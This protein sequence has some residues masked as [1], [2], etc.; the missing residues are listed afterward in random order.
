[1]SAA[2]APRSGR[3]T[4]AGGLITFGRLRAVSFVHSIIY[5]ALL[6]AWLAPGL[7]GPTTVLGWCH[8]LLWIGMSLA[9]LEATRKR[10]IPFWLGVVVVVIGGLGPFAGTI[11]FVVQ[12]R[13]LDSAN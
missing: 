1:M 8:G 2:A 10:V 9:C 4:A 13:R 5:F 7:E 11:G 6:V 12:S 3:P